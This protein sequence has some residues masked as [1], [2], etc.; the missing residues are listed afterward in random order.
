M[1]VCVHVRVSDTGVLC[2]LGQGCFTSLGLPSFPHLTGWGDSSCPTCFPGT[3]VGPFGQAE[4]TVR[5]EGRVY[6]RA[7]VC[8][9]V[10]LTPRSP[11]V[12]HLE[13]V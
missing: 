8:P 3:G 4:A 11:S 1:C 13:N 2:D 10:T 9:V 5:S 7:R 12:D 6:A